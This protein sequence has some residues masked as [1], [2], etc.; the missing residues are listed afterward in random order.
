M[1]NI[2]SPDAPP[3]L[4]EDEPGPFS[5]HN[6]NGAASAV[7]VCDHGSNAV[8]ASLHGLGLTERELHLHI[9]WD[10]GAR[11]VA[12]MLADALD[13]PAV[14]AN[15][16]RLVI[17]CNRRLGHPDS[18][19]KM[20]D[21]VEIPG[22]RDVDAAE[23]ARRADAIFWPYHRKI[24]SGLAGFAM[25]G[26]KPAIISI[27]SFTA[28]LAGQRR[29]WQIGVLWDQ[30]DRMAA[31]MVDALR[32]DTSLVVGENE[33][34]SGRARYGYS[35]EVHATECGL[36]NVLVELREDTVADEDCQRRMAALLTDCLR[37]ILADPALYARWEGEPA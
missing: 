17:D 22:N 30:D 8:P 36:P 24:G 10:I 35:V 26:V 5:V 27:H 4:R 21:H 29:P 25:R 19:A 31:P 13:A 32:R 11:N 3:L 28:V 1:D 20:S 16:S 33:P 18:I 7:V 14:L 12:C 9:A 37:P 23:A 2:A 34:Y 6:G 15:Y